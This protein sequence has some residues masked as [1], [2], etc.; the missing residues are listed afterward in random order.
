MMVKRGVLCL[1]AFLVVAAV[2]ASASDTG[3]YVGAGIGLASMDPN[4]FYPTLGDAVEEADFSF[5]AYGGYRLLKFLAVEAG[6]TDLG[7]PQWRERN[8]QGYQE[9]LEVSVQ[10][11]HAFVVGILPVGNA[12]DLYGK[13]GIMAWDTKIT[14]VLLAEPVYSESSSGS[15]TAYGLG[16]GFWVG[17]NVTLRGEGEWFEIG[18][19][20]TVALFSVNVSYTF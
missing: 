13:L 10:G 9:T 17:P 18:D 2:P 15:D 20:G 16:V 6:Y 7:S 1:A 14:S 3:F 8:V 12:V 5:K 4:D 19:Y 11:W